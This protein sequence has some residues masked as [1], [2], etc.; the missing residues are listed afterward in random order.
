MATEDRQLKDSVHDLL[1][2]TKLLK[3][4]NKK[5][6]KLAENREGEIKKLR[7]KINEFSSE[8]EKVE[9]ALARSKAELTKVS[10]QLLSHEEENKKLKTLHEKLKKEKSDLVGQLTKVRGEAD[11]FDSKIEKVTEDVENKI[12]SEVGDLKNSIMKE[13]DEIKKQIGKSKTLTNKDCVDLTE[14]PNSQQRDNSSKIQ[15][16]ISARQEPSPIP[17]SRRHTAFIAGDSITR[18][19]STGKMRDENLDVQIKTHPGAKVKTLES[20]FVHISKNEPDQLRRLDAVVLHVGT[21]NVSDGDRSEKI[22]NDFKSTISV[23]KSVNPKVKIVISSLIPR[24][25]DKLVNNHIRETNASLQSMC[26][27]DNFSFVNHDSR[28]FYQNTPDKSLFRDNIHLN[29]K[30]GK[31]LGE[32]LRNAVDKVLNLQ[33]ATKSTDPNFQFGRFHGRGGSS[34][35][36]SPRGAPTAMPFPRMYS[37]VQWY[38]GHQNTWY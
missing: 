35:H 12:V 37:P 21:N 26:Q 7:T 19:L 3:S 32:N 31:V 27:R 2:Q 14:T 1:E 16:I 10:A 29:A 5:L 30:G 15:T 38:H 20:T 24:R 28:F 22:V 18:A 9:S 23:I 11:T 34:F 6:I 36:H 4:E 33:P 25:N 13:L 8:K 17:K